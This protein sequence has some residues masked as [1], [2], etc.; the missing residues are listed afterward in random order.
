M[1][2]LTYTEIRK[3]F[4]HAMNRVCEDHKPVIITRQSS[5]PVVMMSLEDY[6]AMEETLYLMR[7]PKNAERL[8]KSISDIQGKTLQERNLID[9]IE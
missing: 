9:D 7:S 2:A 3:N 8:L 1:E 4:A 6:N 5:S